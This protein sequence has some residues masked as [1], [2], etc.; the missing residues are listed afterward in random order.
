MTKN[1]DTKKESPKLRA[2]FILFCDYALIAQDGK[3][4]IIGE[5]DHL[6]SSQDT[7]TLTR[8]FLVSKIS[9]EANSQVNLEVSFINTQNKEPVFKNTFSINLDP[10]GNAGLVMEVSGLTF[11][12]FGLYKAIISS[13]GKA[14]SEAELHVAKA[15][16]NNAV[17]A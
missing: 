12:Q 15:Q 5:F 10:S 2:K 8:G 13:S 16:V 17:R 11:K 14:L 4:S 1:M 6:F 7:A 3:V 9:G